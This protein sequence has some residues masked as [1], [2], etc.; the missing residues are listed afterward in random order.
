MARAPSFKRLDSITDGMPEFLRETRHHMRKCFSR[1]AERTFF[2]FSHAKNL[3]S[4]SLLFYSK[5]DQ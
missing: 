3:F 1:Q 2:L 4:D 5:N